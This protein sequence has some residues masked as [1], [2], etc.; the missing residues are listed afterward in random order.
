[1]PHCAPLVVPE[2]H[3]VSP[4]RA[5]SHPVVDLTNMFAVAPPSQIK[6]HCL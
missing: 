6:P 2:K 1:M 5:Q 4:V 3:T